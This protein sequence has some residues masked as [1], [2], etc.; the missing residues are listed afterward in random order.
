MAEPPTN[1]FAQKALIVILSIL[2][3]SILGFLGWL[4]TTVVDISGRVIRIEEKVTSL[5]E[6]RTAQAA[7]TSA[8]NSRRIEKL[9]TEGEG[10]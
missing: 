8:R 1:G 3:A 6:T 7:E 4:A 2:A 5:L 9:E 10:R